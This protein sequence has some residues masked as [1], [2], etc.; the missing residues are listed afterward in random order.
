VENR[1]VH[2]RIHGL[3]QGV[4]YRAS[5]RDQALRLGVLGWVRNLPHGDVEA[6]VS[7]PPAAVDQFIAWCR[8]GPEEATVDSVAVT[9]D[10]SGQ[11]FSTFLVLR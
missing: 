2:L 4:S 1:R 7:G 3:V 10:T 9:E 5:A 6:V 11:A 8:Q